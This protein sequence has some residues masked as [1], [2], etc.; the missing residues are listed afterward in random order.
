[1]AGI[2]P[3]LPVDVPHV[4]LETPRVWPEVPD[5]PG[6]VSHVLQEPGNDRRET[7]FDEQLKGA[8]RGSE[9]E[10]TDIPRRGFRYGSDCTGLFLAARKQKSE[11]TMKLLTW[12]ACR[13]LAGGRELALV[14]LLT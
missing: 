1:L 6:E 12:N 8:L 7:D 14:N 4:R 13:L 11:N 10:A 3:N 5:D 9:K 2:G